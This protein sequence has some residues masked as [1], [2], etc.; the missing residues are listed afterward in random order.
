M[1]LYVLFPLVS[2]N[3]YADC[4]GCEP[5]K[6]IETQFST[7][8]K[9]IEDNATYALI[10]KAG[11]AIKTLPRDKH[12]KLSPEQIHQVT[13]L[14]KAALPFDNAYA[15][16]DNNLPLF[17]ANEKAFVAEFEKYPKKDAEM[18]EDALDIKLSEAEV[19]QD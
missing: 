8:K 13:M 11:K 12:N 10:A 16:I 19:G 6:K 5:L 7:W 3:V 9:D 14:L 4:D 18:L 2:V 15:I 1:L 17:Q